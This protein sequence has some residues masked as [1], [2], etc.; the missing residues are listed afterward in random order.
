MNIF[1]RFELKY[2]YPARKEVQEDNFDLTSMDALYE[3]QKLR[4]WLSYNYG[5]KIN[6]R[7]S[8]RG[9]RWYLQEPFLGLETTDSLFYECELHAEL[10]ALEALYFIYDYLTSPKTI[11]Q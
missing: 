3:S 8:N 1:Q 11:Q 5:L 10:V 9:V 6:L 2:G 7:W 4:E